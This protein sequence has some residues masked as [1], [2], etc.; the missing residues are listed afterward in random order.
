M[1]PDTD[2][3]PQA[4]P[5]TQPKRI[6]P[7]LLLKIGGA[8]FVPT[9]I[10]Q[11]LYW[12]RLFS[13]R[14]FIHQSVLVEAMF[15]SAMGIGVLCLLAGGLL[16]LKHRATLLRWQKISIVVLGFV[17]LAWGGAAAMYAP[18]DVALY[19]APLVL[20]G[21]LFDRSSPFDDGGTSCSEEP[22]PRPAVIPDAVLSVYRGY[23]SQ[24]IHLI[25][26]CEKKDK[27]IYKI[28]GG[29]GDRLGMPGDLHK[30]RM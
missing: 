3:V 16:W 12:K 21:E 30:P 5:P 10:I 27:E 28:G 29:G 13:I 24:M 6:T 19:R 11:I 26:W 8:L 20:Y 4:V 9:L 22:C 15:W 1:E 25:F 17:T 7:A 2:S 23:K 14:S 18:F